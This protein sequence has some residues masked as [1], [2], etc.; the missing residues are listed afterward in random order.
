MVRDI[1]SRFEEIEGIDSF[2]R[3]DDTHVLDLYLGRD[4]MSCYTLFLISESEPPQMFSARTISV[5]VG[6]RQDKRWGVSF[7]LLNNKYEDVFC[8]F[9]DDII[10]S[11]RRQ[12][13]KAKGAEFVC[14]RYVKWQQMLKKNSDGLLSQA[15]IK[16]L[17]G[18]LLFLK[19]HMIP[20]YGE[21]VAVNSWIGPEKADQ[22]FICENTWY[23][24]KA[25]VS[26]AESVKISS[27]EQL[28]VP[29]DGE[30]VVVYLDKTSYSDEIKITLNS[31]YQDVMDMLSTELLQQKLCDILLNLGY[32]KRTEYDEYLF[33]FTKMVRYSVTPLFPAL[34]RIDIPPSV[35]N[36]KYELSV[37]FISNY[38]KE[39]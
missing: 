25:T 13:D 3:I 1:K 39:E 37:A 22:D 26:G 10:E 7:S 36:A 4:S 8:H 15:E 11:S 34:R 2:R 35:V 23:E 19:Y 12:R 30:L 28:D 20:R 33:K 9:C 21:D 38:M 16:G 14:S 6:Q 31:M 29:V 18:E 17:I 27:V 24:V 32:F 5:Q